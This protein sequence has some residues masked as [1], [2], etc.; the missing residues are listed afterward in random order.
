VCAKIKSI[1]D[2]TQKITKE[3]LTNAIKSFVSEVNKNLSPLGEI[4]TINNRVL[5]MFEVFRKTNDFFKRTPFT[6]SENFVK[7]II[8]LSKKYFNKEPSFNDIN[9]VFWFKE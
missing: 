5:L 4:K 2:S 8:K 6:C 1:N 9:S 7:K 3:F